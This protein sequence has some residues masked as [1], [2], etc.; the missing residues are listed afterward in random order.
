MILDFFLAYWESNLPFLERRL[1]W[2]IRT[3]AIRRQNAEKLLLTYAISIFYLKLFK[4]Q[5]QKVDWK[6]KNTHTSNIYYNQTKLCVGEIARRLLFSLWNSHLKCEL[7]QWERGVIYSPTA[8]WI[9][10]H[11]NRTR[12]IR[13]QGYSLAAVIQWW[14]WWVVLQLYLSR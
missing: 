6:K 10:P 14:L 9:W 11:T 2:A 1:Q 7:W 3:N 4:C 12:Q 5:T 8:S 13:Q